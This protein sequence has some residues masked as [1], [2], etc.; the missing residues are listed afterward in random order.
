M[1]AFTILMSL[2]ITDFK[3]LCRNCLVCV[4]LCVFC[5]F[6][7]CVCLCVSEVSLSVCVSVCECVCLSVCVCVCVCVGVYFCLIPWVKFSSLPSLRL[8]GSHAKWASERYTHLELKCLYLYR[9]SFRG[10]SVFLFVCLFSVTCC[11]LWICLFVCFLFV[12]CFFCLSVCLSVLL[13]RRDIDIL[14]IYIL[15]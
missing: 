6:C 3:D 9:N 1:E 10:L 7:L 5:G 14:E 15:L 2:S 12:P 8:T 13:T 4:C 11:V